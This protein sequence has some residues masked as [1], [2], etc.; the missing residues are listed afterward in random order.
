MMSIPGTLDFRQR[1][2]SYVLRQRP[3][4]EVEVLVMLHRDS[5]EAGVQVPGGG[6][7]PGET[8]GEAALREAVEETGVRGLVLGEVLASLLFPTPKAEEP[9]QV[10][11][12]CWL[13]TDETR[14]EWD[15]VIVSHDGDNGIR[16][17]CEFRPVADARLDWGFD[18]C[19]SRAVKGFEAARL[20]A[21]DR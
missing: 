14:D 7:L 9:F 12:Y 16:M 15:H 5:P 4:R 20:V 8:V 17:H 2:T 18:R 10:S 21:V 19:L 1:A 6:A 3:G 11:T 13:S